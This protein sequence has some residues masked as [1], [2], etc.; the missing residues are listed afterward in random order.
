MST[1]ELID[2]L[3]QQ[4]LGQSALSDQVAVGEW[5]WGWY[6]IDLLSLR[7]LV[8]FVE[9]SGLRFKCP[10]PVAGVIRSRPAV[11]GTFAA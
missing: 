7:I 3:D 10:R 8:A 4:A 11:R 1:E 9:L 6:A 5:W 2:I